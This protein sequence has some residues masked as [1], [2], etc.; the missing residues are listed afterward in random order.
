MVSETIEPRRLRQSSDENVG[1]EHLRFRPN[2]RGL[3]AA[4]TETTPGPDRES[5]Y[6]G[7]SVSRIAR[8]QT[9]QTRP[10][11]TIVPFANVVELQH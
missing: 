8:A 9:Y 11:R 3:G 7:R 1:T 10:V 2:Q 6:R 5:N 4:M